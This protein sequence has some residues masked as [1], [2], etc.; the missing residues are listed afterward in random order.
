MCSQLH[1]ACLAGHSDTVVVLLERGAAPNAETCDAL[2]TPLHLACLG[3]H[4]D[5]AAALLAWEGTEVSSMRSTNKD[6]WS[7]LHLAIMSGQREENQATVQLLLR[8]REHSRLASPRPAPLA[9]PQN[10]S[11]A[12]GV[13]LDAVNFEGWNAVLLAASRGMDRVLEMLLKAGARC[14]QK[15]T[16]ALRAARR[17][18]LF[19]TLLS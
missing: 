10:I 9:S 14:A 8:H 19:L 1:H 3:G 17:Y 7:P 18:F 5:T 16:H 13:V 2:D 12:H 6:G 4:V 11:G 15:V